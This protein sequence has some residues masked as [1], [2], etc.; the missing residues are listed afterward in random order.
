MQPKKTISYPLPPG[1]SRRSW[2]GGAAGA[3]TAMALGLQ[4]PAAQAARMTTKAHIVIAGSGL[5]GIAIAH[6]L[7]ALLDGVRITIVDAKEVHNYQPGYTLVATGVWPVS[8]VIDSNAALQPSGVEWVR[9]MVAEFDPAANALTTT[10]GKRIAYDYLVVAIG[11][12]QDW[13]LIEGMDLKAIGSNGL[14]SVYPS[15]EA[16]VATWAALDSFRRKGGQAVMTLPSTPIKCAG[17]PL[18]MTFM[19]R[20]RLAQSGTLAQSKVTFYS[21]LSNVFGVKS[22]NDRVLQRWQELGI[23]VEYLHTLKAV[24]IAAR[25]ASFASPEGEITKVDYDFIH[26]APPMRAPDAVKNSDLAAQEG[27]MAASGW[28]DVDKSTLQHR[29]YANVFG[30]GDINGTPRGKTAA[31]VKKSA[32]L[33][34]Q[35]LVAVIAGRALEQVF[36]GYTSCPMIVREGS[37]WLIEFDYDG[38]LTPSLPMVEPLHDS[39]FAWLMKI[40]MLKPAY[41]SVLKGRV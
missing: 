17:A 28:L 25:E 35:H 38:K 33:V 4:A 18:K 24:D 32:P 15:S 26:V 5:A 34:A 23:G 13:S 20:D 31:T 3:G 14:T 1:V 2:L 12:H 21:A 37:A 22:V 10:S 11:T 7:Q 29:R 8:K 39:Y 19:L 41:M 6:R 27:P 30:L 9:E 40:H 16:A 36:D